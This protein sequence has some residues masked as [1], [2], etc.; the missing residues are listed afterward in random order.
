MAGEKDERSS[1]AKPA[2]KNANVI[3][4]RKTAARK[5]AETKPEEKA[6]AEKPQEQAERQAMRVFL[7]YHFDAQHPECEHFIHRDGEPRFFGTRSECRAEM[8][9]IFGYIKKR[10]DLRVEP[11][12][13]S[14]LRAVMV[15]V[16][17]RIAK[18]R[19]KS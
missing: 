5:P 2:G 18:A 10:K 3:G 14:F 1:P 15:V 12:G 4:A 19:G 9:R 17:V 16:T 8:E 13:W 6:A 11:H 7:S